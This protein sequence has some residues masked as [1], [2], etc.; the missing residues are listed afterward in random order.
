MRK[1]ENV[2]FRMDYYDSF[3]I[4]CNNRIERERERNFWIFQKFSPFFIST[5]SSACF[6]TFQNSSNIGK[7]C[8]VFDVNISK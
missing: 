1:E 5:I 7:S 2:L 4:R 8:E 3:T 6:H